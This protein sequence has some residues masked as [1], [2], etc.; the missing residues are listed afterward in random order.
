[1]SILQ[2]CLKLEIFL[3]IDKFSDFLP[4]YDC[5]PGS[6]NLPTF[7]NWKLLIQSEIFIHI[8]KFF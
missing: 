4:I 1:M 7:E 6:A 3:S 5:L 2:D 8:G